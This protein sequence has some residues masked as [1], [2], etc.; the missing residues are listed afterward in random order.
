MLLTLQLTKYNIY[1]E[2]HIYLLGL[3]YKVRLSLT[4]TYADKQFVLKCVAK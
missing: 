4:D 3:Y 2:I 1:N